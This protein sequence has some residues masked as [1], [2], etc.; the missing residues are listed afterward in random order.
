MC[1]VNLHTVWWSISWVSL[2]NFNNLYCSIY[3]RWSQWPQS[4]RRGSAVTRLRRLWVRI[5]RG[6][7]MVVFCESYVFLGRGLCDELTHSEESY[8]LVHHCVW[9]RNLKNEEAVTH[10]EQQC[11]LKKSMYLWK[12][13]EKKLLMEGQGM[14]SLNSPVNWYFTYEKLLWRIKYVTLVVVMYT[15]VVMYCY[16]FCSVQNFT[17]S[18]FAVSCDVVTGHSPNV[19]L[20]SINRDVVGEE[21][22]IMFCTFHLLIFQT[23]YS[24]V[25]LLRHPWIWIVYVRT[26]KVPW[27][28]KLH[29]FKTVTA[30]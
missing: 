4:V 12:L 16:I 10:L 23:Y 9:S 8:R 3:V 19:A 25:I 7:W 24:Y 28:V 17:Y 14:H 15:V 5:P 20:Y 26:E 22:I 13:E 1:F 6:T 21:W 27:Q 2:S 29:N 11:H 30:T 18:N